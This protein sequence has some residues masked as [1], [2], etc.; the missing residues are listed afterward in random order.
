MPCSWRVHINVERWIERTARYVLVHGERAKALRKVSDTHLSGNRLSIW[1]TCSRINSKDAC[2]SIHKWKRKVVSGGRED[3]A[4]GGCILGLHIS[5]RTKRRVRFQIGSTHGALETSDL[6]PRKTDS[7]TTRF[8]QIQQLQR[9]LFET[10][11]WY[12]IKLRKLLE[13][14][15]DRW[16]QIYVM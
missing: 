13:K 1:W 3:R 12:I 6:H 7:S 14:T 5:E 15:D 8:D 2:S 4:R 16:R 9:K 10:Q 11:S